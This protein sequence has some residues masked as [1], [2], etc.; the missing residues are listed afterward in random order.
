M[1][2]GLNAAGHFFIEATLWFWPT[3]ARPRFLECFFG[4]DEGLRCLDLRVGDQ[5]VF[6]QRA[7]FT[8][9]VIGHEELGIFLRGITTDSQIAEKNGDR[10]TID[11]HQAL[12]GAKAAVKVMGSWWDKLLAEAIAASQA[13]HAAA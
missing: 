2:P 8:C 3:A 9:D 5:A 6:D 4:V 13:K 12:A 1:S 10:P 11:T 7:V